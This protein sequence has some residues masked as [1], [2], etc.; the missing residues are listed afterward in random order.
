MVH[1]IIRRDLVVV[2]E[3]AESVKDGAASE[4]V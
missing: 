2:R 4:A 3:L 1:D